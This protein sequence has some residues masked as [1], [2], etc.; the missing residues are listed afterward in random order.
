M[1][2]GQQEGQVAEKGGR[3][4]PLKGDEGRGTC[5]IGLDGP[6]EEPR[7]FLQVKWAVLRGFEHRLI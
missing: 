6:M 4:T 3:E 2:K 7:L 1:L 5:H